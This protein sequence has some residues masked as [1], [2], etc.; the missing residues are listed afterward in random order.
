MEQNIRTAAGGQ[1]VATLRRTVTEGG[2]TAQELDDLAAFGISFKGAI[3]MAAWRGSL[4]NLEYLLDLGCDI[5]LI[6]Q[7]LYSYGK[8]PI[9]FAL[10]QNRDDVVRLLLNRGAFVKII[11]NK[12][13]SALSL[14]T[15]SH[16]SAE[17]TAL[18]Q[19]AETDIQYNLGQL[20]IDAL[21]WK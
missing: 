12:G 19:Q 1:C 5:N 14:A 18:I 10:T 20:P 13:Q 11:N 2:W 4:E 7:G 6:S 16:V 3:H 17:T 8:T 15:P 21:G 9:F